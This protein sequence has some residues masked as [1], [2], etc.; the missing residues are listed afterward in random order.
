MR[1][2]CLLLIREIVL[3]KA[4]NRETVGATN[5]CQLATAFFI[6][7]IATPRRNCRTSST[8]G[9][10]FPQQETMATLPPGVTLD[11]PEL[12]EDCP[13]DSHWK[14]HWTQLGPQ[15][16]PIVPKPWQDSK[17]IR[18][19]HY[20]SKNNTHLWTKI[21][22]TLLLFAIDNEGTKSTAG[23]FKQIGT[24]CDNNIKQLKVFTGCA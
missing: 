20:F 19:G 11:R 4:K 3:L 12:A 16:G 18:K 2:I 5:H 22:I 21:K 7:S 24:L 15:D 6:V 14:C 10:P 9:P 17:V 13:L 8:Q 1:R 23:A